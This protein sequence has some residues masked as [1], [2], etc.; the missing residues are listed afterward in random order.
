MA[1]AWCAVGPMGVCL[2]T[3]VPAGKVGTTTMAGEV[4]VTELGPW[5]GGWATTVGCK[6]I[7]G[8]W[9]CADGLM[10]FCLSTVVP[11]GNVGTTIDIG[12]ASVA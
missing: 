9:V 10:G 1:G 11:P 6:T 2:S 12:D 5:L 8:A 7:D 3:V 4:A